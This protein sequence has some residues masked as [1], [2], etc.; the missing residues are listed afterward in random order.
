MDFLPV[1]LD[2]KDRQCLLVGGGEVALRKAR[3]LLRAGARLMV[4]SEAIDD[5]LL[6]LLDSDHHRYR[7]GNFQSE[8]LQDVVLA[9]AAQDTSLP[10]KR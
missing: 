6:T 4:V 2:V 3:L 10:M 8:D 9:V 1:F 7:I 5:G